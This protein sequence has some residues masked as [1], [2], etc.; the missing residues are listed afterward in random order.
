M[1]RRV[2]APAR[3]AP[4]ARGR[5]AAAERLRAR[6][7]V[8]VS[9]ARL[10]EQRLPS[11]AASASARSSACWHDPAGARRGK[12]AGVG[13][14]V[15]VGGVGVRD[16]ES[17]AGR[18]PPARRR[19]RRRRGRSPDARARA[20][21]AR[22]RKSSR[23]RRRCRLRHRPRHDRRDVLGTRLLADPEPPPQR[24]GG[25]SASAGRHDLGEDMRALAAAED[26]QLDRP[27]GARR[28]DRPAS[29]TARIAGRTGL[30]VWTARARSAGRRP[31][32]SESRWRS[33]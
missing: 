30:P 22:R 10:A 5:V 9:A 14:L 28:R 21:A 17:R 6:C 11:S 15:V 4:S 23:F 12:G 26:Q 2:R 8:A 1:P 13:G 20:A 32:V 33:A 18:S 31:A 3:A 27:P 24:L 29:P 16:Q 19:S 25:S 7:G